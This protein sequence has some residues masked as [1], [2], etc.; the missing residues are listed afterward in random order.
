MSSPID[1]DEGATADDSES[2][3]KRRRHPTQAL[4]S[5]ARS[6]SLEPRSRI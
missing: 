3:I 6:G 4:H 1:G 5:V 2:N